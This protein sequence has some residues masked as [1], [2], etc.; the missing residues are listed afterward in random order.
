[1]TFQQSLVDY[2][3]S[4]SDYSTRVWNVDSKHTAGYKILRYFFVNEFSPV[5][6]AYILSNIG[7][8]DKDILSYLDKAGKVSCLD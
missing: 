3:K 2:T 7:H 1:V 8:K 5:Q 6:A 4:V